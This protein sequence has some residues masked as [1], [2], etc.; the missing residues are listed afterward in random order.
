MQFLS[1]N[2]SRTRSR[3]AGYVHALLNLIL[4]VSVLLF[5]RAKTP[6]L[7]AALVLLSKWRVL[8]V[9]PRYWL[10]NIRSNSVDTIVGLSTV[11]LIFSTARLDVQIFFAV[12]YMTWLLFVK[13]K[14]DTVWVSAQAIFAQTIGLAALQDFVSNESQQVWPELVVVFLSF[15][16]ALSCARHFLSSYED[17]YLSALSF[18][19]ALFICELVWILDHWVTFYT[20][21][22]SHITILSVA[23]SYV[24]AR[25]Y[26]KSQ[27]DAL[28]R[29][30]VRNMTVFSCVI[31]L[32]VVLL[33]NWRRS[34][35]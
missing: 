16:I 5:V 26:D 4:P 1:N 33:S 20:R 13:P 31:L 12:I 29:K 18:G 7:A 6:Y 19:W 11:L 35:Y 24:L 17:R 30:E 34:L 10:A 9:Q 21:Y 14:S 8:A 22:V 23:F 32:V 27:S 3:R 28:T 25:L 2:R 15:V